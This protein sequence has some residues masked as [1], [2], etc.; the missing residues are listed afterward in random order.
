[1]K[2]RK[3]ILRLLLIIT[4]LITAVLYLITGSHYVLI[5]ALGIVSMILV[6]MWSPPPRHKTFSDDDRLEATSRALGGGGGFSKL[7]TPPTPGVKE[8]KQK[9]K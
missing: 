7:W 5:L 1:M 2:M 9:R 4:I 6:L 8:R 3:N